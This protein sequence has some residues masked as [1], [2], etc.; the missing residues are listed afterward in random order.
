MF[1]R[2]VIRIQVL[3]VQLPLLVSTLNGLPQTMLKN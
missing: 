2:N 3:Q 1:L